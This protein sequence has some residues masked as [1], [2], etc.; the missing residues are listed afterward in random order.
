MNRRRAFLASSLAALLAFALAVP[1]RAYDSPDFTVDL[2]SADGIF[3]PADERATLLEALAALASNFSDAPGIDDALREKALALALRLDPLHSRSRAAHRELLLGAPPQAV[4]SYSSPGSVAE[5]LWTSGKRLVEAP[6]D[7]EE[8]RLALFLF[9]LSLLV[10]PQAPEERLVEFAAICGNGAPDWGAALASRNGAASSSVRAR[11][12]FGQSRT[13]LAAF[14]ERSRA[15]AM[16]KGLPAGTPEPVP[17]TGQDRV[18]TMP[19]ELAFV[20]S[21]AT[22]RM[23]E[24]VEMEP[25]AGTVELTIRAPSGAPEREWLEGRHPASDLLPLFS[26]EQ[27]IP[28]AGLEIPGSTA[29][30]RSWVWPSGMIGEVRF[31][32]EL[33]VPEPRSLLRT[34]AT[35]PALV[36]MEGILGKKPVNKAFV[37][38][39]EIDPTSMQVGLGGNPIPLIEAGATMGRPYLLAPA[40]VLDPLVESLQRSD[41]LEILFQS[42]LVSYADPAG[43]VA[44]MTSPTDP[45]LLAAS[46][47][48]DEIEAASA[49][50]PLPELARNPSAQERLRNLLAAFPDHLSA[51]AML[52]YGQRPANEATRL[53]QFAGRLHGIVAPFLA[54]EEEPRLGGGRPVEDLFSDADTQFLRLRSGTPV[55]ARNL[56]GLAEDLVDAAELY[57]QLTNK[58]TSI[59]SQRLREARGAIGAYRAE[60]LRLGLPNEE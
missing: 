13:L 50:L 15:G 60:R 26:S 7:P 28:V 46:A 48:F 54:L 59:A 43:A 41:R 1:V 22:V 23:V 27:G 25:V 24:S 37:L 35:L 49:R 5:V 8:R 34:S 44:R 11:E 56:L 33:A 47:A 14:E 21:L 2:F 19:P 17:S 18:S 29:S 45:A 16:A 6:L 32:G 10:H 51:R 53:R 31:D 38:L 3:L 36:L 42:E 9:E 39:G 55:Q 30:G 52:E 57:L 58:G 4:S 20:A 40:T 12:L